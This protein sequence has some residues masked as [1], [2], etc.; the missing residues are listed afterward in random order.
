[1]TPSTII[2]VNKIK[3]YGSKE[4]TSRRH[5]QSYRHKHNTL[6]TCHSCYLPVLVTCHLT[7]DTRITGSRDERC[8]LSSTATHFSSTATNNMKKLTYQNQETI[9][10]LPQDN[11]NWD[12]SAFDNFEVLLTQHKHKWMI[13]LINI[14]QSNE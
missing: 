14:Y 5:R 7:R 8:E 1:M 9:I 2:E 11:C 13:Y 12:L 4:K 3:A 6:H 10:F